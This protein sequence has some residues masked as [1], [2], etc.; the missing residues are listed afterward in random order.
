MCSTT[1]P[2]NISAL[3]IIIN[4]SDREVKSLTESTPL[5]NT[6][7]SGWGFPFLI[8]LHIYVLPVAAAPLTT[9]ILPLSCMSK[10]TTSPDDTIRCLVF[11][12]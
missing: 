10:V 4:L 12:S 9:F 6:T 8:R 11:L 5:S 1:S 2:H 7:T 3:S